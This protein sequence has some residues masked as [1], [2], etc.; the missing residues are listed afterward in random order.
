MKLALECG[1]KMKVNACVQMLHAVPCI[2]HAKNWMGLKIF[3]MIINHGI[4][5]ALK[6]DLYAEETTLNKHFGLF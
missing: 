6:D 2:L 5:H 1:N 3:G 4:K